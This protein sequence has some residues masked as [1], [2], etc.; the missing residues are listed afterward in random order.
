[1]LTALMVLILG[2]VLLALAV[3]F[4]VIALQ[5]G[6]IFFLIVIGLRLMS[7]GLAGVVPGL[8]F[9]GLAGWPIGSGLPFAFKLMTRSPE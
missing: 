7:F 1:M 8:F 3:T 4:L 6:T 9:L 5:L 2:F